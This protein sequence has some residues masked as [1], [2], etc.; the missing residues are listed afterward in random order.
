M[1][2]LLEEAL[3]LQKYSVARLVSLFEDSRIEKAPELATILSELS[4]NQNSKQA[5]MLGFTGTPGAGK[6]TLVGILANRLL[7]KTGRSVA[8]L[9]VDPSSNRSGGSIL[10]DRTRVRFPIDET[11]LYFRSQASDLEL[12]GISRN[13]FQVC[14]L[15]YFLF[16]Y[17][18]IETVGIG[19]S[20][21]EIQNTADEIVLIMQPL[22]GDQIQFMKAGIMEIPDRFIIN[23]SDAKEEARTTY[24]SLKSSL[25]FIR[26]GEADLPIHRTSAIT[27]EGIE[28]LVDSLVIAADKVRKEDADSRLYQK[29]VYYF[30][31]WVKDEYG[32]AG[33][34]YLKT[35]GGA[36][37]W[38]DRNG[39]YDLAQKEF[40][41]LTLVTK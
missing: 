33:L 11:R 26:P 29:E 3:D 1:T 34:H 41:K 37:V 18:I 16:D 17:I 12:G 4:K 15:L 9:A 35:S 38:M 20:E 21:I 40:S 30:E 28:E 24:H 7:E 39:S 19:Q 25:T 32:R 27:G 10:G 8:V 14:R 22:A 2:E 36:S 13:T 31:K 5:C 23:K 6:S